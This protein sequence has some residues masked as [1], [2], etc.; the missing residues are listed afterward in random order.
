VRNV[1]SGSSATPPDGQPVTP[2]RRAHVRVF[3]DEAGVTEHYAVMARDNHAF[4][5]FNKIGLDRDG[6]PDPDDLRL[7]WAAGARAIQLT[8]R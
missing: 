6:N 4:A 1:T 2:L 3:T 7:A 8:P 5:T